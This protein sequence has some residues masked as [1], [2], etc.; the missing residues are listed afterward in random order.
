MSKE[1]LQVGDI[2][3]WDNLYYG[4]VVGIISINSL[5]CYRVRTFDNSIVWVN[6]M[7]NVIKL[8]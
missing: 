1:L 8:T 3:F 2:I 6:Y 7:K 4:L 5:Y